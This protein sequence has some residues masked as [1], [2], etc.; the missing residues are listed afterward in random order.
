MTGRVADPITGK[1]ITVTET[2]TMKDENNFTF[3]M[4]GPGP[5]G[6]TFK[7]LEINYS[8]Q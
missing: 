6:K 2:M 7:T 8:R 3:E 5:G 1:E 4:W